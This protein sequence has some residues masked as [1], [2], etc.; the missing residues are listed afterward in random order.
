MI[1]ATRSQANLAS[2]PMVMFARFALA[3]MGAK[4]LCNAFRVS[5]AVF[6]PM[7]TVIYNAGVATRPCDSH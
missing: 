7:D 1:V 4:Q 3:A 5:V 6:S 2:H